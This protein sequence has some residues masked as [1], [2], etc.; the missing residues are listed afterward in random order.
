[1]DGRDIAPEEWLRIWA[2]LYP[3]TEYP[4]YEELIAKHRS[5]SAADFERIGR[6]KDSAL[7]YSKWKPNVAMVAYKIW[8]QAAS[9]LPGIPIDESRLARFLEDWSGRK[10]RDEYNNGVV[11]EKRFGLSRTTTLLHFISG[12]RFPI[13]DSRV[14]RAS[15]LLGSSVRNTVREYLELYCPLFLEIAAACGTKDYRMLDKALFCYG[16][17]SLQF[18]HGATETTS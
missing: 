13:F 4:G 11:R 9:E 3:D 17:R 2:D 8:M 14:R 7:T 16:E 10:Y 6:W 12:G 1:M 18:P 5:L 15:A